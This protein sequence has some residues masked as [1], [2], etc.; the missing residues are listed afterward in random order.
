MKR[1]II[2]TTGGTIAMRSDDRAGGAVPV[3][4]GSDL[5]AEM[6]AGI[7]ELTTEAVSNLPSA[8][9]TVE[10]IW[11]LARRVAELLAS[12]DLHAAI[13][14]HGT[15]TIEESA[16]LC[17]LTINSDKPIVMT[18]A[19]RTASDIG[20]EGFANLAA[21]VRVAACDAARGLGTLVVMNDE[22][23]AARDVTKTHT[24]A[25]DTFQ[26]P[27]LGPLGYVDYGGVVIARK[28]L[29]RE[30][31]PATRLEP[32]VLLLKLAVGMG[33]E[34]LEL[35]VQSGAHGIVLEGLG[36][37]RVPPDWLPVV[38]RTVQAGVPIV[39]TSRVGSGR[40]VDHYGYL[41]A[42]RDL[43]ECGCWFAEGLNGQK[44]RIKLM[45]ALGTDAPG[46]YFGHL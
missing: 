20:Y 18:G 4:S 21:A 8:H 25:L 14:T 11:R 19:M 28:P 45:A 39:I 22:I 42:H 32:H 9:F 17:D 29:L 41:G 33:T 10:Q 23:H 26:S 44:A 5:T 35:A 6:P 15:D 13:V 37:G 16:F 46:E 38:R 3:L 12:Q 1:I 27:G 36:G 34:L 30:F 24:T 40:T 31:I 7:A 43:V 2:L